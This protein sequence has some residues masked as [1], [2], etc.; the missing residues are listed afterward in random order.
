MPSATAASAGTAPCVLLGISR[1]WKTASGSAEQRG[2]QDPSV[3]PVEAP[4]ASSQP[5]WGPPSPS[6]AA[7]VSVCIRSAVTGSTQEGL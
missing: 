3:S 7:A 6:H 1:V 4:G 5:M 2:A